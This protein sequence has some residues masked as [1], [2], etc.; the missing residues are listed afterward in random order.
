MEDKALKLTEEVFML[1]RRFIRNHSGIYFDDDSRDLIEKRLATRLRK[2]NMR[3]FGDYYRHLLYDSNGRDE[4]EAVLD[5]LTVKETYFFREKKQ[6]RSFTEEILP[7][8]KR[9]KMRGGKLRIWSAGCS[10]GEEPYTIGI[11]VLESGLFDDRDVE[12]LGTDISRRVIQ[13]AR[14]GV[15]REG[16]FR[17]TDDYYI[18]KYFEPEATGL[19]KISDRVRRLVSFERVNLL[20]PCM[21]AVTRPQDVV[22]CRNALIYF[23]K[24]SRRK[25]VE[26]FYKSLV[27][28]GYLLL[29]HAE[30]LI[31]TATSFRV[32]RLRHDI[33]YQKPGV[34]D[35]KGGRGDVTQDKG[36]RC[37]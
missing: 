17:C 12:I 5:L 8:L 13:A 35:K 33:V 26:G 29:G 15:Y 31:N 34:R 9:K 10:T 19:L 37:R 14:Q 22:F 21:T 20:D 32:K 3:S 11:L 24:A 25:V 6:L 2:H 36:T 7:E 4:L 30:S 28:G 16:S 27:E 23:D 1:L 18:E